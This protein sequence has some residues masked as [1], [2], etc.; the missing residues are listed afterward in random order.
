MTSPIMFQPRIVSAVFLDDEPVFAS[1]PGQIPDVTGP[2][3]GRIDRWPGDCVRR[4]ANRSKANWCCVFPDDPVWNL[5]AR[6]LAFCMLNPQ[7]RV[8]RKAGIFVRKHKWGLSSTLM[9]CQQ[10]R[11]L[12]R[13]AVKEGMAEDLQFWSAEDWQ[14]FVEH[15]SM[16]AE[17]RTVDNVVRAIRKVIQFSAVLTGVGQLQDPWP[18]RSSRAVADATINGELST[19]S[20]AP[21]V[22]WP[23]LRAAWAYIDRF[24]PDILATRDHQ[25]R[26]AP[27][28]DVQ[29]ARRPA[30]RTSREVD[31]QLTDWLAD[32]QNRIPVSDG[33]A[34]NNPAGAPIWALLS[35]IVTTGRSAHV[36]AYS[37]GT[38]P[39]KARREQV[40]MTIRSTPGRTQLVNALTGVVDGDVPVAPRRLRDQGAVDAV[41]R[42]WLADPASLI[43]VHGAACGCG[44]PGTPVWSELERSIY[45]NST[46]LGNFT[47]RK[48][49]LRRRGWVEQAA[50]S[51]RT[52]VHSS[53]PLHDLRMVRAACYIFLAALSAM[54][55]SEIQEIQ[56]GSLTQY[57]GS[58]AVVSRKTKGDASKPRDNWWITEPVAQAI[59]VAERLSWHETHIFAS[60]TPP[61]EGRAKGSAGIT[62]AED[63]DMFVADVN[64]NRERT[65]LD[66]IPAA[67]VRP[68][69]FRRT[70]SIIASQQPDGEIALGIQLKHAARRARANGLTGAYGRLDAKWAK[71]FDTQLQ[72]AAAQKLVSL[73]KARHR[74]EIVA[75]G[76][77][78]ARFHAALDQVNDAIDQ[79]PALRGQVADERLQITLLRDEFANLHLG[80]INHCLW[81]APTAECQNQL[82]P[83][84][85][86]QEPLLGACQPSRCRNSVLTA[87][88]ERIWRLDED[89]LLALLNTK[90]SKPRRELVENRLAEVR[91]GIA[92]IEKL[93]VTA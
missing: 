30:Q 18:G 6:E 1:L 84:Q 63:I 85:R 77:G 65:G 78:A 62:A 39:G 11:L 86:G 37:G 46:G 73:L 29:A 90:L 27:K 56:R 82:P 58:P 20:I 59:A 75:A 91:A 23:L 47:L 45:G 79:T 34:C 57:F 60:L 69:M 36:F 19:E 22:W 80:T 14:S 33:I 32:P 28:G 24:A 76:P 55:D 13:W 12:S 26:T 15:R 38:G 41:V 71:E 64:A 2:V 49:G 8:L 50:A 51:G 83:E 35:R 87:A 67:H 74:G 66:E 7:H 4:P 72:T 48:S 25:K 81:N 93:K 9:V 21:E 68:H 61:G 88:H 92:Q 5:R 42:T 89:Q 70:M 10:I 52:R 31:Q 16:T 3:F 40:L 54:R 44:T 53:G 17:P 43:P